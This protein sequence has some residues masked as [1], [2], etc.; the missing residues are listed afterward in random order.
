[1]L[2][3]RKKQKCISAV[4]SLSISGHSLPHML[5]IVLQEPEKVEIF[6]ENRYSSS[7][8]KESIMQEL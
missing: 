7:D 6:T 3:D 5:C 1:M 4:K 2:G 8:D